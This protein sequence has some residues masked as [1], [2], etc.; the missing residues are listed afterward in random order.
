MLRTMELE[1]LEWVRKERNKPE[2]MDWFRQPLPLTAEE[3]LKWF[4]TTDMK[5]Y[6]V[7]DDDEHRIGVVSLS[8][9]DSIARKCEFSIMIIPEFR[10][11]GLGHKA[12]WDLLKIAFDNLN[13]NQV[14]SDSFE[15]NPF[16]KKLLKWGFKQCGVLPNWY[17]K[18]GKY[19]NSIL[20]SLSK[21]E[22]NKRRIK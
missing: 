8:H 21:D 17:Y 11:L 6:V 5:S 14:Y 7:W 1:D 22:Y 4:H 15:T 10:G 9:I 16:L 12:L 18:N 20:L 19:I 2:C 13:M 3:Q